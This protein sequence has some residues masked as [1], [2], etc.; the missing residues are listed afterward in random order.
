MIMAA[1]S[2]SELREKT[3]QELDSELLSS[4]DEQFK[5]RMRASSSQ[6]QVQPHLI[7]EARRNI[8]R[9]KTILNE[10]KLGEAKS[11]S[12]ADVGAGS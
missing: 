2:P 9:I 1:L 12:T 11:N 6:Q 5:L 4:L 8:A 10:K 7:K 3:I